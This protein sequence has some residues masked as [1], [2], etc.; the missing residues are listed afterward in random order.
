MDLIRDPKNGD[1]LDAT[2]TMYPSRLE[3]ASGERRL[4]S[5]TSTSYGYVISGRARVKS[6]HFEVRAEAGAFFSIPGEIEIEAS[7]LVAVTERY[8]FRGLLLAGRIEET[9]RLAYIDG[10]SDTILCPPARWGDPVLNY[11]HFP[12]GVVQTLHTHPSIRLGVVARGE[13]KAYG[14]GQHGSEGWELDLKEG[15]VFLLHAHEMHAF[16]TSESAKEMDVIAFHPDS[17]W[18]PTDGVHPMLN[19]TYLGSGSQHH[20]RQAK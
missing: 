16:R 1:A 12:R 19:R 17:D 9:G 14:P 13:G 8:G 7:G 3:V 4:S 11:L 20:P 2:L 15:M 5:P 6:A 10:C 18:G